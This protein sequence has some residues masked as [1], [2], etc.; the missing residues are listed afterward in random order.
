[1][2]TR[3]GIMAIKGISGPASMQKS[4]IQVSREYTDSVTTDKKNMKPLDKIK[5]NIQEAM[6]GKKIDTSA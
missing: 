2:I 6:K 5:E 1:M 3:E 4:S